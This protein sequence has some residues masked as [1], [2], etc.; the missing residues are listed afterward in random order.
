[1]LQNIENQESPTNIGKVGIWFCYIIS[2]VNVIR[3]ILGKKGEKGI[4]KKVEEREYYKNNKK[5]KIKDLQK[6]FTPSLKQ[7][8]LK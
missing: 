5:Q 4:L 8:L 3:K 1:M 2:L 6:I 7:H